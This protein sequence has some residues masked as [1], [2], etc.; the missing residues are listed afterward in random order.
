MQARLHMLMQAHRH[1]AFVR[2]FMHVHARV[3][4]A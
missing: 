3:Q 1:K 2:V 4:E